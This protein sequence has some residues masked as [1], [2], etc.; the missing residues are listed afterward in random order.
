MVPEA[1]LVGGPGAGR[2]LRLLQPELWEAQTH[3]GRQPSRELRAEERKF[4]YYAYA[5]AEREGS[6]RLPVPCSAGC[7]GTGRDGTE[8]RWEEILTLALA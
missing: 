3:Q 7:R 6:W 2:L 8:R 4:A 1:R 5:Q